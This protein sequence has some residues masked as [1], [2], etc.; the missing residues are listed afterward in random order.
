MENT[1]II[2]NKINQ[3]S[4]EERVIKFFKKWFFKV[5]LS[6]IFAA[7]LTGIIIYFTIGTTSPIS[8]KE[9]SFQQTI[10]SFEKQERGPIEWITGGITEAVTNIALG[11]ITAILSV[12]WGIIDGIIEPLFNALQDAI[13]ILF[14][15]EIII[16][17][18]NLSYKSWIIIS[19]TIFVI[20][21]FV[22]FI[23]TIMVKQNSSSKV[24]LNLSKSIIILLL[25][26]ILFFL[27]FS[28]FQWFGNLLNYS[29]F[30][31]TSIYDA[32]SKYTFDLVGT[33]NSGITNFA[34]FM[35]GFVV[36]MFIVKWFIE[37]IMALV[38]RIYELIVYGTVGLG[39]AS[40]A[41]MSDDGKRLNQYN[42][43]M[44]TKIINAFLLILGYFII[45][46][47][48]PTINDSIAGGNFET[49]YSGKEVLKL[50][51]I[52]STSLAS[53]FMLKSLST[54]W[55]FLIS[56]DT[57]GALATQLSQVG[58]MASMATVPLKKVK[59]NGMAVA[60]KGAS[61]IISSNSGINRMNKSWSK[62]TKSNLTGNARKTAEDDWLKKHKN[63]TD[64]ILNEKRKNQVLNQEFKNKF[65]DK[66][67]QNNDNNK[68]NKK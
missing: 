24:F 50:V 55:A 6:L 7:I 30:N 31:D 33:S 43:V 17:A 49:H 9:V 39:F 37:F 4:L 65:F 46:Y 3:E 59:Q 54:E 11:V 16:Q 62:I 40:S 45:I 51:L 61:K 34:I 58:A 15:G 20:M 22:Y 23:F 52:Y 44:L 14:S 12:L 18:F 13:F 25:S 36:M 47:F 10:N 1:N 21:G 29:K 56:G 67:D 57:K 32:I 8:G 41:Y 27:L 66:K 26:P 2:W 42:S 5:F 28:L 60:T 19:T 48:L 68:Q 53:F 38:I 63:K 35:T 64:T